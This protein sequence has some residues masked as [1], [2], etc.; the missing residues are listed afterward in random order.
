MQLKI[1]GQSRSFDSPLTIIQLL[2]QLELSPERV[3]IE[4]NKK[5]LTAEAH[6]TALNEGDNLEIIQFVG[7]G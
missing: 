2:Q 4:L 7:G 1:N 6:D 3:V 5:I